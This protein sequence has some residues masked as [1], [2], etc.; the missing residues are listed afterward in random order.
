MIVEGTDC[1]RTDTQTEQLLAQ[2]DIAPATFRAGE[3]SRMTNALIGIKFFRSI[4]LGLVTIGLVL[5]I[6]S[7]INARPLVSGIGIGLVTMGPV[8]LVMDLFGTARAEVYLAAL[9][10]M[11]F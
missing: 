3:I 9:E 5:C 10:G 1:L 11:T 7:W 4:Q 2:L 8:L 6:W